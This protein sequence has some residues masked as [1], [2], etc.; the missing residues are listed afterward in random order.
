MFHFLRIVKV[1]SIC[2]EHLDKHAEKIEALFIN[3]D[4]GKKG[5][6]IQDFKNLKIES[7]KLMDKGLIFIWVPKNLCFEVL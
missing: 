4:W 1:K 2:K 3:I 7:Y 5:Q 6:T